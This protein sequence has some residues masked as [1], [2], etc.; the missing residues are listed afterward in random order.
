MRARGAGN[1]KI[2]DTAS[3]SVTATWHVATTQTTQ[4]TMSLGELKRLWGDGTPMGDGTPLSLTAES[5][6]CPQDGVSTAWKQIS[7]IRALHAYLDP[8]VALSDAPKGGVE[9]AKGLATNTTLKTIHLQCARPPTLFSAAPPPP[10]ARPPPPATAHAL[11]RPP[12]RTACA[13][14]RDGRRRR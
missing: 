13:C 14:A 10:Q 2:T 3:A 4:R 9:I 5:W 8:A 12:S 11:G 7:E 1:K 6:V